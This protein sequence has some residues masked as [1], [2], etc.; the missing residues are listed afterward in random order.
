MI[1]I[2]FYQRIHKFKK[3]FENGDINANYFC[4]M[5]NKYRSKTPVVFNIE[6]T[7]DCNMRCKMC[8]RTTQMV[9]PIGTMSMLTFQ[10]IVD[11]IKPWTSKEWNEW[12]AFVKR[13]YKVMPNEMNENHFFFYI[14]P[15]VVTLHGFG[16]PLRDRFIVKRIALLDERNIPSYFSSNPYNITLKRGRNLMKAGLDYF[17]LSAENIKLFEKSEDIIKHLILERDINSYETTFIFD[18]VGSNKD[19]KALQKM[20]DGYNVYIYCK[21]KDNQWYN[22]AKTTQQSIHWS[23]PCQFPWSSLSI[24]W[25]GAIVPCSQDFNCEM[26]LGNVKSQSLQ[27]VWN[28][29]NYLVFRR[30]H[31]IKT[32]KNKCITSCDM[33]VIGDYKC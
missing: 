4:D 3:Q 26:V 16:E 30:N 23:E 29:I 12:I 21:S 27:E 7:N 6:T 25:E 17:K 11:Q 32:I 8:P 2:N 31:Y 24:M 13:S 1:D 20:F 19:Y 10:K 5:L 33:K 28:G 15:K 14:V 22:K 9:R 18:V